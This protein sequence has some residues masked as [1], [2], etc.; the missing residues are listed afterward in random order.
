VRQTHDIYAQ[1]PSEPAYGKVPNTA[2]MM[3]PKEEI[4]HDTV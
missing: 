1:L 3:K 4:D 2:K